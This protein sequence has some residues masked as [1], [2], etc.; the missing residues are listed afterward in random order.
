VSWCFTRDDSNRSILTISLPRHQLCIVL[1]RSQSG[2][3]RLFRYRI[4]PG[5]PRTLLLA[6]LSSLAHHPPQSATFAFSA[7]SVESNLNLT[8]NLYVNIYGIEAI[9]QTFNLCDFVEGVLCP[10]PQV[11]FTG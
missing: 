1:R 2:A 4:S 6:A 11:N 7:A 5:E 3:G 10:L 9:N 8:A